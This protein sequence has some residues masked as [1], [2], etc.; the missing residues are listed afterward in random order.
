LLLEAQVAE[1]QVVVATR[2]E[3]AVAVVEVI[4]HQCQENHQVVAEVQKPYFQLHLELLT[5]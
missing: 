4:V 3:A 5:Q 2:K 1:V